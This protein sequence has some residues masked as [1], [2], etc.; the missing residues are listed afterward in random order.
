[1]DEPVLANSLASDAATADGDAP[2][3]AGAPDLH[4]RE[5]RD[6]LVRDAAI[7]GV[8]EQ[9]VH[10]AVDQAAAALAQAPV[11]SFVGILVERAVREQLGLPPRLT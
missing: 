11:R 6:R 8:D 4:L 10:S 1:M 3:V 2:G 9:L 5:M 7:A